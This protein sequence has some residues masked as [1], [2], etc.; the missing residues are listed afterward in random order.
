[1]DGQRGE[2]GLAD[3]VEAAAPPA[4]AQAAPVAEAAAPVVVPAPPVVAEVA[5]VAAP[6]G[7]LAPPVVVAPPGGSLFVLPMED[8]TEALRQALGAQLEAVSLWW[9]RPPPHGPGFVRIALG[10]PVAGRHDVERFLATSGIRDAEP[11]VPLVLY[12]TGHGLTSAAAKHF[13]V[14]RDTDTHR[15]LATGLRTTEIVIAALDSHARDVLVIVNM[16]ESADMAGELLELTRDLD[17]ARTTHATLNVLTTAAPKMQVRGGEFALVLRRAHEWLRTAGGITRRHLTMDEF[18]RALYQAAQAVGAELGRS[19]SLDCRPLMGGKLHVPTPALPNPGFRP[20]RAAVE[21]SRQEVAASLEDLGYWLEKASGRTGAEDTGWYFSGRRRLNASVV[22]FLTGPPGI[23]VVTGITASGK[24]AI[25]G[26]AVTLSDPTFR[27]SALFAAAVGHCPPETVPDRG[28]VTIAVTAHHREPLGLLKAVAQKLGVAPDPSGRDQLSR[29]QLGLRRYLSSPGPMVTVVVDSLDEATDPAAALH[30]VLVPLAGHLSGA[31]PSA[32]RSPVR[33]G[34]RLV[35]AVRSSD[36]AG[37]GQ[38]LLGQLQEALPGAAVLRTDDEDMG[39][40]VEGYVRALLDGESAWAGHDL[41][42]VSRAV[43]GAVG[44]SF[45]DARVAAGQLRAAGPRLAADADWLARLGAEGTAGL[46][47]DDLARSAED[48]LGADEA[49]ALLRATAFAQG[50]GIA[51]GEVWPAVASAVR[52]S[53]VEDADAKIRVLLEGRLAGYLT[54]DVEEDQRVYRPAHERLAAVLRA[55]PGGGAEPGGGTEMTDG[56]DE[57]ADGGPGAG[58]TSGTGPTDAAR[59]P[60]HDGGEDSAHGYADGHGRGNAE[61]P[62]GCG[63]S[64]ADSRSGGSADGSAD[65]ASDGAD[66]CGDSWT[67][68]RGDGSADSRGDGGADGSRDTC[69]PGRSDSRRDGYA[70]GRADSCGDSWAD[71]CGDGSGDNCTDSRRD[72]CRDGS[73]DSRGGGSGDSTGD[74]RADGSRDSCA[75][76]R[77]DGCGDGSANSGG[78]GSAD[79]RADSRKDGYADGRTNSCSDSWTDSP[80]DGSAG[81]RRESYADGCGDSWADSMDS[82]A[83]GR[84]DSCGD[85]SADSC[86]DGYAAARADGCAHGHRDGSA[87]SCGD[88]YA[89]ARADGCAH[90]H[91]DGSADGCGNSREGG[92]AGGSTDNPTDEHEDASTDDHR[93]GYADGST[94]NRTDDHGDSYA[95]SRGGGPAG[96]GDV[97]VHARIARALAELAAPHTGGTDG[98]S[99]ATAPHPY[100]RRYLARHA[101]LG[102]VLDDAHVP[103]GVLPWLT[104]SPVRGLLGP[105]R[106]REGRLWLEAWAAVEPYLHRADHP[107]RLASLQLAYTALRHPGL[108][109]P[110]TPEDGAG[111]LAVLWSRWAPPVNVL[112]AL[113]TA[114]RSLTAVPGPDG[115]P[116]LAAGDDDGGIELIDALDGTAVRE[117]IGAHAGSVR[118][119]LLAPRPAQSPLLVSGSTDGTLR[120]WDPATGRLVDQVYRPG[121]RWIADVCAYRDSGHELAVVCVNGD[122]TVVWWNER[123]GPQDLLTLP[124]DTPRTATTALAALEDPPGRPLLAIADGASLVFR[125]P[126][127]AAE[128][129]RFEFPGDVRVLAATT[130]PGT[131]AAGHADGCVTV[132]GP[133]GQRAT[134]T[135]AGGAVGS[136]AALTL[137]ERHLLAAGAGSWIAVWDVSRWDTAAKEPPALLGGHTA[138]VTALASP[139]AGLL[140]SASTDGTLRLWNREVLERALATARTPAEPAPTGGALLLPGPGQPNGPSWFALSGGRG[141]IEVRD[142][143][144]G[145]A[146]AR[147]DTGRPV[148][149]LAWAHRREGGVLVSAGCDDHGIRLWDVGTRQAL[150]DVL[151]GHFLP[152]RALAACTTA[153]GRHLLLSGGDDETVRLWDLDRPG[154]LREWTGHGLRVLAVAA[155]SCEGGGEWFASA[156]SDGTVRLWDAERGAALGA[157]LRCDQGLLH[158]V[159]LNPRPLGG[160]PPHLASGGDT[161][162]VRLW[163][164]R[165]RRPLGEPLTGHTAAVHALA[166]WNAEGHGSFVASGAA[167]GTIRVWDAATG[168]CRLLLAAGS[169]VRALAAHPASAGGRVVLSFAGDAGAAAVEIDLGRCGAGGA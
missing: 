119:L 104:G 140:A 53:P 71:S 40:D 147:L 8:G 124:G 85:G 130:R 106:G 99:G 165:E 1:M 123:M 118:H 46:L 4:V 90:G 164:L 74:S 148:S 42:G 69:T 2:I 87:D 127:A 41:A 36:G 39:A 128:V 76:G 154:P 92:Y 93:D 88:G 108:P 135:G 144:T 3:A 65:G 64:W 110:R 151:E 84:S 122:G 168:R 62:D 131:V 102:G 111:P 60:G 25:L 56:Q 97:G 142:I 10:E 13:A 91:R 101:R 103:P 100:V 146:V 163:D 78:D 125:D 89:A 18:S 27:A 115:R 19:L 138:A 153:D 79:G 72:S 80:R 14:L 49:L 31:V 24:S 136:L 133:A 143:A 86:G 150:P 6:P 21:E 33:R 162:T 11:D 82:C 23:L 47:K 67:D 15:L 145:A 51:W 34:V 95:D 156:G 45:L 107:S 149:A 75:P 81:S 52:G 109:R 58:G 70:D 94:D 30:Q 134:L 77:R 105:G 169:P 139:E 121:G 98:S 55:W 22:S 17:T 120:L 32:V 44:R 117:R 160:V 43:A 20:E 57:P 26:R 12:V 28:A 37:E 35:V 29:W 114:V 9:E 161:G 116:A 157:P 68:S 113:D 155:A 166:L 61:G 48:G 5:V 96:D 73:V 112:A 83:P 16:C 66:A 126:A 7:V 129:A 152:V 137:G 167:D 141:D 54:R 132:W 50:R 38:D 63:D 159:A 59:A 158:A